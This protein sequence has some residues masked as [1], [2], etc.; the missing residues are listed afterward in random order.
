MLSATVAV[1]LPLFRASR[2]DRRVAEKLAQ[3]D[4]AQHETEDKRRELEMQYRGLRAEY[5]ALS[6][7]ATVFQ[8]ELLPALKRET[9]VTAT[10]FARDQTDYRDAQLRLLD[11]ELEYTRLRVDIARTHA[12]L[13]YLAGEQQP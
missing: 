6:E 1:D 9:Q 2:Q 5:E 12:E 8:N 3:A 13:L 4:G 10:G 7:R 11:A